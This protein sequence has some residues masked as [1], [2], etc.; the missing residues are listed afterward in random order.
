MITR[1]AEKKDPD[2]VVSDFFLIHSV[3]FAL[4]GAAGLKIKL[5][6]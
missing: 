5:A 1:K 3:C 6:K 4:A 2:D